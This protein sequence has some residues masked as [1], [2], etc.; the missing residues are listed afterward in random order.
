MRK[1][2]KFNYKVVLTIFSLFFYQANYSQEVQI[3]KVITEN[4]LNCRQFD[5]E[6]T[7]TGTPTI[8][9]QEV[10]LLIDRSG[11]MRDLVTVNGVTKTLLKTAK[12]AAIDFV[13]NI[14][15]PI[16]DPNGLN[17]VAII[18]YSSFARI[19]IFLTKATGKQNIINKI[20]SISPG[21]STNMQDA[22][23]KAKHVLSP[24][25]PQ[26]VFDCVTS[27]S[28]I[29]LTDGIPK[30]RNGIGTIVDNNYCS[31]TIIDTRCQKK[32]FTAAARLETFT[33]NSRRFSQQIFTIGFTG[34]LSASELAISQHTLNTIENSGA[35]YT[36]NA[37]D[38]T[39]IYSTI[40]GQLSAAA[41]A[42][43]GE[44]LMKDEVPNGF[45]IVP[46]SLTTTKGTFTV[47]GQE[48]DW[49]VDKVLN[50]TITLKYSIVAITNE[51]GIS[52]PSTF[53]IKYQN[54]E[55]SIV[56]ET[57][58]TPQVCTPCP[59]ASVAIVKG[60]CKTIDYSSLINQIS[61]TAISED[62]SWK[63]F[64][65]GNEVGTSNTA[66]GTFIYT[67]SD[68]FSGNFTAELDYQGFYESNCPAT[69]VKDSATLAVD[70][71]SDLSLK[72]S[73]DNSILKVGETI[74]YTITITNDGPEEAS[75]IEVSN[76]LPSGL[77]Y[78]TGSNVPTGTNFDNGSGVWDLNNVTIPNGGFIELSLAV[79]VNDAG[80]FINIAEIT[81]AIN[82]GDLDSTPNNGR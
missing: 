64:L 75:D 5:V 38:L 58:T 18:S 53:T 19:K 24:P 21:G 56:E 8:K 57:L 22:L 42:V 55:C 3:D 29:L 51:C 78:I 45:S 39:T 31:S 70:C 32:A 2:I 79:I 12:D 46:N 81:R 50:E 71:S 60:G 34:S 54:S 72:V 9:P 37:A 27:R 11:S 41:T 20:N 47:T 17:R 30:W 65:N 16:N 25:G 66:S 49:F 43:D 15:D 6:L 7:I 48:I 28:V 76:V 61:C 80:T 44:P 77:T 40:L 10:V 74:I 36:N 26:G 13:N 33:V 52:D 59:K 1:K 35:F 68:T 4:K 73:V 69:I 82:E 23:I 62:Y 67:G 63:F 14:F